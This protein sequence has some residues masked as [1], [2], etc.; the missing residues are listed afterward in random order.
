M[1]EAS[2]PEDKT[3]ETCFWSS[4]DGFCTEGS[5]PPRPCKGIC[6]KYTK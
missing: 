2:I 4:R 1:E 3:C 5:E 6:D